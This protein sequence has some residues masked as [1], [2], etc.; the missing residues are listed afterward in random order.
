MDPRVHLMMAITLSMIMTLILYC[1]LEGTSVN[2][3]LFENIYNNSLRDMFFFVRCLLNNR[4][5]KCL[6]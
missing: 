2:D 1:S 4:K 3:S 5:G 6:F